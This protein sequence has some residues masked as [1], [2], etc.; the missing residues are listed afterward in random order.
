MNK[1]TIVSKEVVLKKID[2]LSIEELN[3]YKIELRQ[4][5]MSIDAEIKV[6]KKKKD[7]AESIFK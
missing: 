2:K 6:R 7:I 3:I 5:V 4:L 1:F